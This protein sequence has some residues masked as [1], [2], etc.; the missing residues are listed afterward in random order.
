MPEQQTS[1]KKIH[2]NECSHLTNHRLLHKHVRQS[3]R[4]KV[5]DI[6]WTA[7]YELFACEGCEE[8]TLRQEERWSESDPS[9]PTISYFPPRVARRT[10]KWL[11][12]VEDQHILELLKEVYSTLQADGR[13]LAM[14]GCRAILDRIMVTAVGDVGSFSA[15]L[16]KMV[17]ERLLSQ[18]DRDVLDAAID[19]GNAS[20]HRGYLPTVEDLHHV[21]DIVE[22]TVHATLLADAAQTIKDKTPPRPRPH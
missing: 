8:V 12:E 15:K 2:C 20:S 10:P 19:A 13:R 21:V 4:S 7:D 14:M 17:S 3:D 11:W 6:W 16:D 22:H 5:D 9:I 1:T 18:P